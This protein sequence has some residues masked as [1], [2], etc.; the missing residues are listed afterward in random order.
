[1]RPYGRRAR[2][3]IIPEPHWHSHSRNYLAILVHPRFKLPSFLGFTPARLRHSAPQNGGHA[4]PAKSS[5][6]PPRCFALIAVEWI[7]SL[8]RGRNAY[9]L[10]DAISSLNLGC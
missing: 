6:W 7:I 1:M 5:F 2:P 10:A 8:R 9:G 3:L 4:L